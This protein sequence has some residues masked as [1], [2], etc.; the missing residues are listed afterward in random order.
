M[1][2]T[3]SFSMRR[4]AHGREQRECGKDRRLSKPYGH[5]ILAGGLLL[6]IAGMWL[7][8][9][10]EELL[11][12]RKAR[13]CERQGAAGLQSVAGFTGG[14]SVAGLCERSV[15][16]TIT[17]GCCAFLEPLSYALRSFGW[18][19]TTRQIPL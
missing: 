6:V 16:C 14:A 7:Y 1:K 10:P 4:R 9:G 11:A 17:S 19:S 2:T 13:C 3:R 5:G 12:P 15:L 8:S 18:P